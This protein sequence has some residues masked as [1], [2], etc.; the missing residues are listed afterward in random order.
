MTSFKNKHGQEPSTPMDPN[1][2]DEFAAMRVRFPHSPG[3]YEERVGHIPLDLERCQAPVVVKLSLKNVP[4]DRCTNLASCVAVENVPRPNGKIAAM[5]LCEFH[6]DVMVRT[7]GV[8]YAEFTAIDPK[9]AAGL[10]HVV[11]LARK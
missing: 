5:S 8:D 6:R 2:P 4:R 9:N 7:H 10:A 3:V 1:A 11:S